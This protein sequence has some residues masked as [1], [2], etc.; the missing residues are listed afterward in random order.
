MFGNMKLAGKMVLFINGIVVVCMVIMA[1]IIYTRSATLQTNETNAL[2]SD[3]AEKY[4]IYMDGEMGNVT[5]AIKAAKVPLEALYASGRSDTQEIMEQ[6]VLGSINSNPSATWTYFYIKDASAFKGAN[7]HNPKHRLPNGDFLILAED[8]NLDQNAEIVPAD[9]VILEFKGVA[10][11]FEGAEV[12]VSPPAFKTVHNKQMYGISVNVPIK[13]RQGKVIGVIGALIETNHFREHIIN[14]LKNGHIEGAFPFVLLDDGTILVHNSQELQGKN[15]ADVNK[16][17]TV[18]DLLKVINA[19]KNSVQ[20]YRTTAGLSGYASIFSF[21]A[22]PKSNTY[23]SMI[24]AA[25]E[26]SVMKPV[27]MLRNIIVVAVIISLIVIGVAVAW[28]IRSRVVARIG[29]ISNCL[30]GFFKY[31]NHESNTA[32][33]PLKIVTASDELGQMGI[34]LNANI[35]QTQETLEQ[36]AGV[37][38]EVTHMVD[39]AKAGRFG[40]QITQSTINKQVN[41]L[42]DKMNEMSQ[43][44]Y[45]L[46]GGNLENPARVFASY[47]KNDFTPRIDN[48]QGLEKGVN[49]LGDSIVEMLKVSANFAKEL[50][51]QSAELEKS[52]QILTEGSQNQASSLEESATAVEQISSS[53]QNVADRTTEATRQAGDIKNIVSVIKDI[54]E[55]TNLLALNAAI[56]AARAG[57]HGRGFAVVADEVRKLAERTSKSLGEIE[58][59]VNVLVQSVN[60]MSESIREQTEGLTQINEAISQLESVTQDNVEV[61]NATNEVTK[62]VSEIAK[63]IAEDTNRKKY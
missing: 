3:I 28:Y 25:P 16:D 63:E 47:Q 55:Q 9:S 52:M 42:K 11:A 5:A 38:K 61:A 59:N 12:S 19:H 26:E 7:I 14:E 15:I 54:A 48:P 40:S 49:Q 35:K 24:V 22:A 43:A 36:D 10:K 60:E 30:Q 37:I 46:V 45:H 21:E 23:W 58:A 56:E 41:V 31:L 6:V 44:L 27:N 17:S 50:E 29:R 57:E 4:A 62:R 18:K 39:E 20:I 34:T 33:T 32:P 8:A 53:M 2:I 13:D 51:S 1:Y